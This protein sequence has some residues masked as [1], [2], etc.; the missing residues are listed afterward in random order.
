MALVHWSSAGSAH[1]SGRGLSPALPGVVV[2]GAGIAIAGTVLP[3]IVKEFF[4]ARAG[5]MTGVYMASMM[6]G[7][8]L[9]AALAVPLADALD[10]WERS[11]AAWSLLALAG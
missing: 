3:G 10:S 9:A 6:T 1:A 8:T 4:S 5:T 7:A 11:L 2:A